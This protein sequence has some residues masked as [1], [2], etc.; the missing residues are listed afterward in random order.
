MKFRAV[1]LILL[2][3]ML[4]SVLPVQADTALAE[5]LTSALTFDCWETDNF[6]PVTD[7][8]ELT[9]TKIAYTGEVTVKSS[10]PMASVYLKYYMTAEKWKLT[11]DGKEYMRGLDGFLHEFVDLTEFS[12]NVTEFTMSFPN[13]ICISEIRAFG[14]GALPEDIQIWEKPCEKADIVLFSSHNDDD[15]LFFAGVLPYSVDRGA[16]TQVVYFCEHNG[17]PIRLHEQINGLWA[18]GVRN[19]PVIGIFP[20]LYSESLDGALQAFADKGYEYDDFLQFQVDNIRRFKPQV[21]VGHDVNGEYGHGTHRLNSKTLCEAIE[22]ANDAEKYPYSAVQYGVWDTPKTYLHLLEENAIVMDFDLPLEHF[23]G[24]TA[25]E[26][27][28]KGYECHNSQHY[29]WFTQWLWGT[30]DAPITKAAQITDYSPCKYGLWRTTVGVDSRWDFFDHIELYAMQDAA[31]N[32]P[33]GTGTAAED[34]VNTA[35]AGVS[36][37]TEELSQTTTAKSKDKVKIIAIS[38]LGLVAVIFVI[39]TV[40]VMSQNP[41]RRRRRRM[42]KMRKSRKT[43]ASRSYERARQI[44]NARSEAMKRDR[45][46]HNKPTDRRY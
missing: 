3:F 14:A 1:S 5:E 38:A 46:D 29:S 4:L 25:Y 39:G 9:Y 18:C 13:G 7:S 11:V 44:D 43:Q 6:A 21:V 17:E 19:Y 41:D 27:S 22:L 40:S 35:E 31:Q 36:S 23:G 32:P 30:D 34:S 15:Q 33:V 28:G 26:M 24:K 20:D 42:R 12:D 10:K 16:Q 2:A 8:N 37:E 45:S